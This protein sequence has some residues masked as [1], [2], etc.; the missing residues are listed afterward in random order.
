MCNQLGKSSS[1]PYPFHK[2]T[3]EYNR[4]DGEKMERISILCIVNGLSTEEKIRM[5]EKEKR[6]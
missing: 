4:E 6:E 5:W 1:C 2:T 3:A